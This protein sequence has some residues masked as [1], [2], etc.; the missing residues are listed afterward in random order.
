M[1]IAHGQRVAPAAQARVVLAH[2]R[3]QRAL[4]EIA[5]RPQAERIG[6]DALS[7]HRVVGPQG[8][9]HEAV[10]GGGIVV[11]AHMGE[12]LERAAGDVLEQQR[13]GEAVVG[14][15]RQLEQ[16]AVA[17]REVHPDALGVG[18]LDP[19]V[20]PG[21]EPALRTVVGRLVV[22]AAEQ[23][24]HAAPPD[25][26]DHQLVALGEALDLGG[27]HARHDHQLAP[28]LLEVLHQP[29]Q[30]DAV[31]DAR[32]RMVEVAPEAQ[33]AADAVV[34]AHVAV[35]ADVPVV[36]V[37]GALALERVVVVGDGVQQPPRSDLVGLLV[38]VDR[39]RH[40]VGAQE[41]A[42]VQARHSRADDADGRCHGGDA[43]CAAPRAIN[44]A[45]RLLPMQDLHR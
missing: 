40:V 11:V 26:D 27:P 32:R 13:R 34:M 21:G 30:V 20:D 31:V 23:L 9:Q 29:R 7:G 17:R 24:L 42:E 3:R 16:L 33:L 45:V 2:D 44:G 18:V 25:G 43:T 4:Q 1:R 38:A 10:E 14:V 6:V 28:A 15:D 36:D 41:E 37:Q 8:V 5:A 35:L 22:A 19:V 39:H 12:G